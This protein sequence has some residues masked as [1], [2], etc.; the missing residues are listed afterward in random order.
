[1]H[2]LP[3]HSLLSKCPTV[4]LY[5][6]KCNFIGAHKNSTAFPAPIFT[7][8]KI[9]QSHY[10]LMSCTE[11]HRIQIVNLWSTS[12]NLLTI[13][14]KIWLSLGLFVSRQTFTEL[15]P[16]WQLFVKNS[17]TEFHENSTKHLISDGDGNRDRR[18]EGRGPYIWRPYFAFVK[19]CLNNGMRVSSIR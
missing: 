1:V 8:L 4:S 16:A 15:T 5:T 14:S 6:R 9:S 11:S 3:K 12:K 17:Y 19:K 10:L 2:T 13:L 18:T 7:K